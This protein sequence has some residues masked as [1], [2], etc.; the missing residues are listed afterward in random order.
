VHQFEFESDRHFQM[1][2]YGVGHAQ[3]LLRSVKDETHSTRIDVLFVAVERLDL[4]TT[5]NGLRIQ[6]VD[7]HFRLSGADWQGSVA[8]G[9][10][11]HAEDDGEYNDP[12]PFAEGCAL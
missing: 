5:L 2:K 6:R 4:P 1:W 3:L 12:S 7:D 9:N 8:A 10:V 11:A